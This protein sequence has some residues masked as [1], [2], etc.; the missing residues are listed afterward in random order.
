M[1]KPGAPHPGMTCTTIKTPNHLWAA[2]SIS[3]SRPV[4]GRGR[5]APA[6]TAPGAQ[7]AAGKDQ[8]WALGDE[9]KEH[10]GSE[11]IQAASRYSLEL[12]EISR[13]PGLRP[14][15]REGG[16]EGRHPEKMHWQDSEGQEL[17]A[18]P[19]SNVGSIPDST[20]IPSAF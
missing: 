3:P 2:V 1:M 12:Q 11:S 18:P 20:D 13:A 8:L 16:N 9:G 19:P 6:P 4:K 5:Q 14:P 15:A 7:P 10:S 17:R